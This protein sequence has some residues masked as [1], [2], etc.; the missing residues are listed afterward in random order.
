MVNKNSPAAGAFQMGLGIP[1]QVHSHVYHLKEE[2]SGVSDGK[3]SQ[4]TPSSPTVEF[5]SC[6]FCQL[7]LFIW[8][9][10]IS[11]KNENLGQSKTIDSLT[12]N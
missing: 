6:C 12:L 1:L 9:V 8:P 2:G 5:Q 3:H 11:N 10:R 4:D 7:S